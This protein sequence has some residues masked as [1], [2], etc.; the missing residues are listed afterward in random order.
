MGAIVDTGYGREQVMDVLGPVDGTQGAA[1][2]YLRPA[3]GGIEWTVRLASY[4]SILATG[5]DAPR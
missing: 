1:T 2:V 5:E 3:G 4:E